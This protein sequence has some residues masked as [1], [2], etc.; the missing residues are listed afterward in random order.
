M[1]VNHAFTNEYFTNNS[2]EIIL[3][4]QLINSGYQIFANGKLISIFSAPNYCNNH[5]NEGALLQIDHNLKCS[6]IRL[7]V[8]ERFA[9]NS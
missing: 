5:M 7:K 4:F 3:K 9:L 6:I 1:L 2:N 8:S